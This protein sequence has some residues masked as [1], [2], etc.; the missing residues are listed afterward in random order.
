MFDV[1]TKLLSPLDLCRAQTLT[2][3]QLSLAL[4]DAGN[5]NVLIQSVI[6]QGMMPNGQFIYTVNCKGHNGR[7]ELA[8]AYVSVKKGDVGQ[9]VI[10]VVLM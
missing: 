6:F 2:P 9:L 4:A 7:D 5:G 1:N 10:R 8:I 3:E